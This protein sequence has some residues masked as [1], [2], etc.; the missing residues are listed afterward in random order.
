LRLVGGGGGIRTH[1]TLSGLTVFKTAAFDRSATPPAT[2]SLTGKHPRFKSRRAGTRRIKNMKCVASA[3][4]SKRCRWT[5]RAFEDENLCREDL[6][7][8]AVLVECN[9]AYS[10]NAL[11]WL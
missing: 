5:T 11:I 4:E 6:H 7:L 9:A 3:W 8:V 10:H 2:L 1:E